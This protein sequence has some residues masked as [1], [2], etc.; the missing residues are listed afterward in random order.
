MTQQLLRSSFCGL[1]L[2]LL[3]VLWSVIPASQHSSA[4]GGKY[5]RRG[6]TY[7]YI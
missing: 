5:C 4:M 3:F 2:D 1:S 6:L 7:L